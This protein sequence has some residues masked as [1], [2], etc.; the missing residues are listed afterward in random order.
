M[1]LRPLRDALARGT[2]A[3]TGPASRA[4]GARVAPHAARRV[5]TPPAEAGGRRLKVALAL[6]AAL[7]LGLGVAVAVIVAEG[8]REVVK[9]STRTTTSTERVQPTTTTTLVTP[10]PTTTTTT[11]TTKTTTET[12]TTTVTQDGPP[13]GGGSD[14]ATRPGAGTPVSRSAL[15]PPARCREPCDRPRGPSRAP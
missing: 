8:P 6:L 13:E 4:L 7:A 1:A 15:P 12:S 11:E 9:T 14:S 2:S 10:P 3:T 5:A